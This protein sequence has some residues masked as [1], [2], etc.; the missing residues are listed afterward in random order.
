MS[1]SFFFTVFFILIYSGL[2]AQQESVMDSV[3]LD[4]VTT[5]AF[6]K[7]YQA[8]AKIEP[9]SAEQFRMAEEGAIGQVLARFTPIYIKS[10]AGGLSTIHL[11]G[12]SASQTSVNFGGINLNSLTVGSADMSAIPSY[13]FD[14]VDVQYG[15]SSAV[16]G[17]GAVGGALALQLL[18][19]WT[20]GFRV[21]ATLSQG[22]FGEQFYG[23]KL[24]AGNG[25]WETV[26]RMYYFF[27]RNDFPFKNPYTGNVEDRTPVNDRQH[28]AS[29]ENRGLIQELNYLFDKEEYLKSSIWLEHDWYQVQPNM[30]INLNFVSGQV[31]DNKNIRAWSEYQNKKHPLKYKAGLGYVHDMQVYDNNAGQKI[32]TD[33]LVGE[34]EATQDFSR[35]LG[36]KA[37]VKYEYVVP[38][39][40]AYPDSVI[41][42]EQHL[43]LYFSSFLSWWD[44]LKLTLNLRQMY[45]TNFTVPFTPSVG[46][47]YRLYSDGKNG[48]KLS[49]NISK[50]YR[51]PTFNDRYWGTQG[52][53]DLKPEDGMNYELGGDYSFSDGNFKAE[54]KLNAFYMDIK[55]WIEWRNYGAWQAQNVKEV[56]SK[57]LEFQSSAEAKLGEARA[58]F[59]LNYSYNPVEAIKDFSETGKVGQQLIYTPRHT[60]NLYAQIA[61][62]DWSFHADGNYTGTRFS[63]DMGNKMDPFFVANCGVS[64]KFSWKKQSF[65]L[66]VSVNN[67]F[68]A[69]Y[70]NEKYYAMPGRSFRVGI[71]MDLN[72]K[73]SQSQ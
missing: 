11:R 62:R 26:T 32:G 33:R 52:N 22:S 35:R 54:F 16:N 48:I 64:R 45:V 56:V 66:S 9:V 27:R 71:S 29:V 8:G 58:D 50:S 4:E 23:T 63:D 3:M 49:S 41:D 70:Q 43:E 13:L 59:R 73:Q 67:L 72:I 25:K 24:Y 20:K 60:G 37:G 10:N 7:K 61:C 39:V 42:Y 18:S 36:V 5:V 34:F 69:D 46:A 14:G 55:N 57:G 40:Y 51:V 28:W 38:D 30:P 53:P 12:T 21:K 65:N 2:W 31:L 6:V 68:N 19:N 47:E 1:R 15:S 17:S 44:R